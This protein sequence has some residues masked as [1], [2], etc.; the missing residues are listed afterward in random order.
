[1]KK[2]KRYIPVKLA[3][4]MET[5]DGGRI[6]GRGEMFEGQNGMKSLK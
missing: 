6:Y 3:K 5:N 2:L 1:M 4:W